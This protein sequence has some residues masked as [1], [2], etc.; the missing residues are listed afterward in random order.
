MTWT[1]NKATDDVLG[2][3]ETADLMSTYIFA[4]IFY[5]VENANII[6]MGED[7]NYYSFIIRLNLKEPQ[8]V[9]G[10]LKDS[11][12]I[13]KKYRKKKEKI[14]ADWNDD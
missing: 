10:V 7:K 3:L 9:K 1:L 14:F 13:S 4:G 8:R 2:F 6:N 11:I 5:K 12:I